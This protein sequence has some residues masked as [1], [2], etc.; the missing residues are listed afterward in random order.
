MKFWWNTY[1][2]I[3]FIALGCGMSGCDCWG[4]VRLV[5]SKEF[6]IDLPGP[7]M[8]VSS[9][10]DKIEAAIHCQRDALWER[11]TDPQA[12]DVALFRMAGHESHVGLVTLP[13]MVLHIRQGMDSVIVP[14]HDG[15][16]GET[17][18]GYWHYKGEAKYADLAQANG[19]RV[20]GRPHPFE[21]D[22]VC[23]IVPMGPSV[24][25]IITAHC[26]AA[27]VP[28]KL[29]SGGH[30]YIRDQYIP[31][32]HWPTTYPQNGD[33]L[34]FRVYPKGDVGRM[35]GMIAVVALAAIAT[36]W[37][38]GLG[39]FAATGALS[40]MGGLF[41]GLAGGLTMMA[42]MLAVNALFPAPTPKLPGGGGMGEQQHFLSGSQN[43]IRQYG[44][45]PQVLG[46][47]RMTLDY[48][49]K[50]YTQRTSNTTNHLRA[51]YTAGYGPVEISDVREGDNPLNKYQDMQYVVYT[52]YSTDPGP[53]YYTQ[54]VDEQG[55]NIKLSKADGWHTYT[56]PDNTDQIIFEVYHPN[57]LWGQYPGGSAN[58]YASGSIQLRQLPTGSF[59]DVHKVIAASS[60]HLAECS[61]RI[62]TEYIYDENGKLDPEDFWL[63][64][65]GI[66]KKSYAQYEEIDL[67][68]WH[69]FSL[70]QNNRIVMRT[71]VI[72][73]NKNAEPSDRL[74]ALMAEGKYQWNN[75]QCTTRLPALGDNEEALYQ[76]CVRGSSIVEVKH[77]RDNVS[78]QGCASTYI[79][80]D[81]YIESGT[82]D[83]GQADSFKYVYQEHKDAFT[84]AYAYNVTR[85]KYEVRVRQTSSDSKD[86]STGDGTVMADMVWRA[87]RSVTAGRPFRPPVPIA[88]VEIYVRATNQLNGT[89]NSINAAVKSV[90]KDYDYKSK[91]WLTR[92]SKNPA[93]LF[94]H[95]LQGPAIPRKFK[96]SE[97]DIPTLERWHNYC[98]TQ[99]FTYFRIIGADEGMSTFDLLTEIT[100]AGNARPELRDGK[101]TV[102]IDEPR[103]TVVQHFTEHNSWGFIG[104]KTFIDKPHAIRANFINEQKGYEQDI[105]T[106]YAD[107][108]GPANATKFEVWELD[109]CAGCTNPKHII[110]KVRHAMYWAELRP[111]TYK[112]YTDIEQ[113][114]CAFGDLVRVTHSVPMWGLGSGRV[115]DRVMSGNTCVGVTLDTPV[116]MLPTDRYSMRFRLGKQRG[117]TRKLNLAAVDRHDEYFEVRFTAGITVDI[118]SDGDLFQFGLLDEESRELIVSYIRPDGDGN[119]EI[120]LVDYA[121]AMFGNL[122]KPLPD[123]DSGITNPQPLPKDSIQS[124]PKLIEIYSDDRALIK[125]GT[126]EIISR[127]GITFGPPL[128][129]ELHVTHI[130]LRYAVWQPGE[131]AP[132]S[133][134]D[135]LAT[136]YTPIVNE[137]AFISPVKDG[138]KY[139]VEARFVTAAG[140]AG[141]W[142]RL[143]TDYVV[144][145][146]M[147]RPPDVK[148]FTAK[149]QDAA[150]I[151]LAWDAVTVVDLSH[152]LISGAAS[153]NTKATTATVQV[154]RKT[155]TLEFTCVAVDT[156]KLTSPN[157]ATASV[158]V[159][160][161]AAPTL[162]AKP[163]VGGAVLCWQNCTRTWPLLHYTLVDADEG[164]TQTLDATSMVMR[165]RIVGSYL[166]KA[167]A[168]DIFENNSATSQ[169]HITVTR[170]EN[171]APRISVDK[172]DLV[173]SWGMV[174][175]FFP[176]DFYEVYTVDWLFVSRSKAN[177]VRFPAAGLGVMEYRVRAVDIA[178]N[179]SGWVEVYQEI[180]PP[181]MPQVSVSLNDNKDGSILNWR[182]NGSML[183]IVAWDVVRQWEND[184][185]GFIETLEEDFGRLDV[186]S[187]LLPSV[188]EGAHHYMVR[189]IDSAGNRSLWG[190]AILKVMPPGKVTFY[191]CS[192]IDN[193]FFLYWT[194]PDFQFFAISHY[195]FSEMD[196]DGYEMPIGRVDAL[197]TSAFESKAGEYIYRVTPVDVAGN[198]GTGVDITMRVD[199][200]PDFVLY[201]DYDSLFNGSKTH[202]ALD[203]RGSMF[204][205]VIEDETWHQNIERVAALLA[206]S[207]DALTWQQ[208]I[209][210]GYGYYHSPFLKTGNGAGD[211]I[212]VYQEVVDVGALI[213]STKIS[214]TVSKAVLEGAPTLTCKIEVSQDTVS[215]TVMSDNALEVYATSFRYVRY[216]FTVSGGM[217]QIKNINYTLNIKRK[218]DFGTVYCGKDDNGAAY[219]ADPMHIGTLVSFNTSFVDVSGAPVATVVNNSPTNPLTAYVVF[220]DTVNP[221]AFRMFVMDKNG[222]RASATVSWSAQGV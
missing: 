182:A 184:L 37:V 7:M 151:M 95:V 106:V 200:P 197:F 13:G 52:G 153:A 12:G 160:P 22:K 122:D 41:G 6:G 161:P 85:G 100:A 40:G 181:E 180:T 142:A 172:A 163:S 141:E 112:I 148:N 139:A 191:G 186:D 155:G 159:H 36:W 212:G 179:A 102:I 152:Y 72:T 216:T 79:G 20:L 140:L 89:M 213:P 55:L 217:V 196:T 23:A 74:L 91:T 75:T 170:P 70:D 207:P 45:L 9:P 210:A 49:G 177:Q 1:V 61:P 220:V 119:A 133:Y 214:V 127:I 167:T 190:E 56:T 158:V 31:Y 2:G 63:T 103:T 42:G 19:I 123:F 80:L 35:I 219:P 92:V 115:T 121:P 215:W 94:R 108:Y 96:D 82:V 97:L 4:L 149:I 16:F 154:Y 169:N 33:V 211:G 10:R 113:I 58:A 209:T 39:V 178:G 17:L 77:T 137:T 132:G 69:V 64:T 134:S 101:W 110:W 192:A 3:P 67:Y 105:A 83:R 65:Y 107:G 129:E 206:V 131:D 185:G 15:H 93:S 78:V 204:G 71:G 116:N 48:L 114:I 44:R 29:R 84:K 222:Q 173:V 14:I 18:R 145:G 156:S 183:P 8:D 194:L 198:A 68:Q 146:K 54:D 124:V 25:D 171:P 99:G 221:K 62:A 189:A 168:T 104:T 28:Q 76:V 111:N 88:R 143:A 57:G 202:M 38:G 59:S 87:L 136:N 118:P 176:I 24:L 21:V 5:Y 157:P 73:D 125:G 162:T 34:Y 138:S 30:V 135:W 27:H 90:V 130:Q 26:D 174:I 81:F 46:I 50:P 201:H 86:Q 166:F 43:S 32:E 205:P 199:Q 187:L 120:H 109:R 47:G 66:P 11:T 126:G 188:T 60:F 193:N 51:A 150:G 195:I 98:R 203:G 164:E 53:K 218:T 128:R 117:K 147:A 175:S 208:K 144:I 165:P